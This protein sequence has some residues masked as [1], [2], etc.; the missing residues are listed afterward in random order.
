MRTIPQ[1]PAASYHDS[2]YTQYSQ[3]QLSS[4]QQQQQQSQKQ[5]QQQQQYKGSSSGERVSQPTNRKRTIYA[6]PYISTNVADFVPVVIRPDVSHLHQ[7]LEII[8]R[9]KGVKISNRVVGLYHYQDRSRIYQANDIKN[10]E[11]VIYVCQGEVQ[12][13]T[14]YASSQSSDGSSRRPRSR[15]R[16]SVPRDS[17]FEAGVIPGGRSSPILQL[18]SLSNTN[19]ARFSGSSSSSL[20]L[21]QRK[22]LSSEDVT[23]TQRLPR[24]LSKAKRVHSSP[25]QREGVKFADLDSPQ[26]V[27]QT[28]GTSSKQVHHSYVPSSSQSVASDQISLAAGIPSVHTNT[29]NIVQRFLNDPQNELFRTLRQGQDDEDLQVERQNS[30]SFSFDVRLNEKE[31]SQQQQQAQTGLQTLKS[32]TSTGPSFG[33]KDSK[34]AGGSSKGGSSLEIEVG[35]KNLTAAEILEQDPLHTEI[36]LDMGIA[37]SPSSNSQSMHYEQSQDNQM[38]SPFQDSLKMPVIHEGEEEENMSNSPKPSMI[39][40]ITMKDLLRQGSTRR[41]QSVG[42]SARSNSQD[43]ID[44]KTKEVFYSAYDH[45]EYDSSRDLDKGSS[46]VETSS[47]L[48][49]G[50]EQ[51]VQQEQIKDSA[52]KSES[53]AKQSASHSNSNSIS[54]TPKPVKTNSQKQRRP[55]FCG[56]LY[57]PIVEEY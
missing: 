31:E 46:L 23:K 51:Q 45:L 16:N 9:T 20:P 48:P 14:S 53:E 27:L 6:H 1:H 12:S 5:H 18:Q 39:A 22:A 40:D 25:N 4:Q 11:H 42:S 55:G 33:E 13:T 17:S 35:G 41:Q 10:G 36:S 57:P 29:N 56:C 47:E 28:N 19:S 3:M 21:H 24:N 50:L 34:R 30:N 8:Q 7:V 26:T 15:N 43:D 52:R 49:S 54:H 2:H 32:R 38:I 44:T 37:S